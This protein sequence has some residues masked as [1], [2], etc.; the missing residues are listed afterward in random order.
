MQSPLSVT[1]LAR[2]GKGHY[3][4]ASYLPW[5]AAGQ[6]NGFDPKA[7]LSEKEIKRLDPF[8]QYAVAAAV[9]I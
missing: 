1:P 8:A 3:F 6:L 2:H 5:N 9:I 7:Y 4:D